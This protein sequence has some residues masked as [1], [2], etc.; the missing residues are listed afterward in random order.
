[1]LQWIFDHPRALFVLLFITLVASVEIGLRW[2][3]RRTALDEHQHKQVEG[4]R[5]E[6]GVLLSLLMGFTLAMGLLRYDHRTELVVDEANAIGTTRLRAEMLPEPSRERIRELLRQYVDSRVQYSRASTPEELQRPLRQSEQ[7]QSELWREATT[8]A[9]QSP[10]PITGL[11]VA[12][13][14]ESFDIKDKR[15]AGLENRVPSSLWFPLICIAVL[16]C[17]TVGYGHS[18]RLWFSMVV[19]PL[20]IAIVMMLI[21]DLDSARSG[22]VRV[23]QESIERLQSD[24]K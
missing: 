10:N 23:H 15:I 12:S 19:P 6:I 13:L 21:A 24:A 11:F 20:M 17:L 22:L 8:A 18:R 1:M 5:N 9:Q 2:R 7:L 3:A 16:A 4:T 14:N